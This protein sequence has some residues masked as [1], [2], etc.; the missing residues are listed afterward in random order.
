MV[1]FTDASGKS[2]VCPVLKGKDNYDVWAYTMKVHL[3]AIGVHDIVIDGT[4]TTD[5]IK[6]RIAKLAL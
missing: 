5:D 2:Y 1:K 4:P 6:N 3:E